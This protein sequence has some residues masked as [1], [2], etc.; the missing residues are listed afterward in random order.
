MDNFLQSSYGEAPPSRATLA[1]RIKRS[2]AQMAVVGS[3]SVALIAFASAVPEPA[4]S[5]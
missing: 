1:N 2:F 3:T 5:H 4:D